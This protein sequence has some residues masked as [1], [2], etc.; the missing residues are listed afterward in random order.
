MI[1][2]EQPV[3]PGWIAM[4]A[5]ARRLVDALPPDLKARIASDNAKRIYRL[6]TL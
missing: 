6:G 2:T 1:P 5:S 3:R 4:L